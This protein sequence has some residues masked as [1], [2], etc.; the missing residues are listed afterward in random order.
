MKQKKSKTIYLATD[1]AGYKM[2][3]KLAFFLNQKIKENKELK[4]KIYDCGASQEDPKDD[5]TDYISIAAN[6]VSN[7]WACK[8]KKGDDVNGDLA[9]I[10]G[11]SGQGEAMMAN[12]F[13]N[14]RAT[15]Y[16]CKNKEILKLS[17][18]HNDANI[19]SIGARFFKE[20][21]YNE[22]FED[23][24]YWINLDF[25]EEDRH[26]R[27]LQKMDII[28]NEFYLNESKILKEKHEEDKRGCV[29]LDFLKRIFRK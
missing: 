28:T 7:D 14:V 12:R 24:L 5:Y 6:K 17:K 21:Q 23:I 26:K 22:L 10:M 25:K 2:K 27:R 8:I 20:E 16:Y 1:H 4:I 19:L 15:V 13:Q 18:L 3:E 9:I 11:G 29:G